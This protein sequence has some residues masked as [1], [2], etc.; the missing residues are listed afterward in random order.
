MWAP[1][2]DYSHSWKKNCPFIDELHHE[3]EYLENLLSME[4][5]LE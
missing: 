1:G 2:N 3:N 4:N 5:V